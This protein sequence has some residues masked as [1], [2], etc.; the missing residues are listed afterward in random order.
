M[1]FQQAEVRRILQEHKNNVVAVVRGVTAATNEP[2]QHNRR[3]VPPT[4]VESLWSDDE[5]MEPSLSLLDNGHQ[6]QRI[7]LPVGDYD[8]NATLVAADNEYTTGGEGD[9]YTTDC[10]GDGYTTTGY[11]T[12]DAPTSTA[13]M[14]TE[15]S[16]ATSADLPNI[17]AARQLA[18]NLSTMNDTGLTD[19][20]G[21][22]TILFLYYINVMV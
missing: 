5:S 19:A 17:S 9:G 18:D 16:Y 6:Q 22:N 2:G 11:T 4:A 8:A 15:M 21:L 1:I 7:G 14:A 3:R 20:E 10:D 13:G 12:D